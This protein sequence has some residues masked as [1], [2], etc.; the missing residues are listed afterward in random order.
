MSITEADYVVVGSGAGGSVVAD[1]LSVDGRYSVL[2]LEAGGRN[3]RLVTQVPKA[4]FFTAY[5]PQIAKH[6]TKSF[7]TEEMRPG[8]REEWTRG[9]MLGGSTEV[10]GMVCLAS[11]CAV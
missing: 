9:R 11:N 5:T 8:F 2:L 6:F 7:S 4:F 1:R 3:P 10:N